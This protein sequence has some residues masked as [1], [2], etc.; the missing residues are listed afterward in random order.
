MGAEE[1]LKVMLIWMPIAN[2]DAQSSDNLDHH[3]IWNS[4]TDLKCLN[5]QFYPK[6]IDFEVN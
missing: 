1:C 5:D 3:V 6:Y 2:V 4:W